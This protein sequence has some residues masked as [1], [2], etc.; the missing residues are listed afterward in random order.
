M[1]T[2]YFFLSF[3]FLSISRRLP[4]W[5]YVTHLFLPPCPP[6]VCSFSTFHKP[7]TRLSA[8]PPSSPHQ[9]PIPTPSPHP[10]P[11]RHTFVSIPRHPTPRLS[12][13]L[14]GSIAHLQAVSHPPFGT[15][16]LVFS[17][18]PSSISPGP[19]PASLPL[20][21]FFTHHKLIVI[22]SPTSNFSSPVCQELVI[23][24][25]GFCFIHHKEIFNLSP[26]CHPTFRLFHHPLYKV[27]FKTV[28]FLSFF[29]YVPFF[30]H[31]C[32]AYPRLIHTPIAPTPTPTPTA[33]PIPQTFPCH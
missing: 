17:P 28:T 16:S 9:K 12:L 31:L 4:R 23:Q 22:P 10:S 3:L 21:F 11:A 32:Y 13:R 27:I 19:S 2:L 14:C 30:L 8:S 33:T 7:F 18:F 29:H 6:V 1:R 15:P 26:A 24:L 5:N 20:R 25:S